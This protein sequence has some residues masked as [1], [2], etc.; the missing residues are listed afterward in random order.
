[1]A[2]TRYITQAFSFDPETWELI[3]YIAPKGCW[4]EKVREM[5]TT[6]YEI[7]QLPGLRQAIDKLIAEY[8]A[9]GL[10]DAQA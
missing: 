10:K 7:S 4:S 1:M 5:V 3:Q 6:E 9:N 8:K 2:P